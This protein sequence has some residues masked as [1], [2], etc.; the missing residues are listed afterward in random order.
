MPDF[1]QV[2]SNTKLLLELGPWTIMT[3]IMVAYLVFKETRP[4]S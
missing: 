3:C 4:K 2:D 1:S